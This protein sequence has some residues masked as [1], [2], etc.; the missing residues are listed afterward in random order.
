MVTAVVVP[1]VVTPTAILPVPVIDVMVAV[2]VPRVV[3][4]MS[5][6]AETTCSQGVG[7]ADRVPAAGEIHR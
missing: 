7:I 4:R 5:S 6:P 2:V 3:S 1:D